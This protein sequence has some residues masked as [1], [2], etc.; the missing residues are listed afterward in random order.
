MFVHYVTLLNF[1]S[2]SHGV[3]WGQ[4]WSKI[5]AVLKSSIGEIQPGDICQLNWKFAVL[6]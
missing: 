1:M 3:S 4:L 5:I 6:N 2:L